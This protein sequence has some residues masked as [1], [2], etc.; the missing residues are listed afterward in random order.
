M[1]TFI[2]Q[3]T[4][5]AQSRPTLCNP[6]DCSTP[7]FPKRSL[8]SGRLSCHI[9]V[10]AQL[11]SQVW[12]FLTPFHHLPEFAQIHVHWVNDAIQP[13][14]PLSLPS[15]TALN[16]SQPQGFFQWACFSYQVAK[17][18]QLQLGNRPSNEYS[19]L[20]SLGLTDLTF[21]QAKEFSRVFS[22]TTIQKYQFF[23]THP[24]LWSNSHHPSLWSKSHLY[25]T[26]RKIIALTVQ[27]LVSKVMSLLFNMLSRFVITLLSRSKS[28]L[29]S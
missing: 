15:P 18:L 25:I 28:L 14:H 3:F 23:G 9:V 29:I 26:T 8:T 10:F 20:I 13:S 11:L 12:L 19:G 6:M 5:V 17:S 24:S 27:T 22:S 7:G 4:S 16:L 2:S 1:V 21:L